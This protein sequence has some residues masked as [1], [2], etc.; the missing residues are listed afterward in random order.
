[1]YGSKDVTGWTEEEKEKFKEGV[2]REEADVLFK[3]FTPDYPSRMTNLTSLIFRPT[4]DPALWMALIEEYEDLT[5]QQI[6]YRQVQDGVQ[7]DAGQDKPLIHI[8][9]D[10]KELRDFCKNF[11]GNLNSFKVQHL[12]ESLQKL[13]LK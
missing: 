1:M 9:G 8:T 13:K 11:R 5:A 3:M 6:G 4:S 7:E 10:P 2:L 12:E